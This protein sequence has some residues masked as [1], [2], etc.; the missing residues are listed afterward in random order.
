MTKNRIIAVIVVRDGRVVQSEKFKHNHVIHYDAIHAI[1]S[2]SRWNVDEIVVLNVSHGEGTKEGFLEIIEKVSKVCWVPLTA[3][4][5]I[6]SVDYGANLIKKGADKLIIN[7]SFHKQPEIPKELANKF[8]KQCIV[9]S[10]DVKDIDD[11]KIVHVDRGRLNTNQ[12][13]QIW[14]SHCEKH[15]A[16][17]LFINN[18]EFDGNRGGYD[19]ES[20][21]IA[22]EECKL[23]VIIFGGAAMDKHFAQGI[24]NGASGVAAANMF[25][26]KEMATKQIKRYL[27]RNNYSVRA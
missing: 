26:Y 14:I 2:F 19:L 24:E 15:G 5:F 16:G 17:E 21:K 20:L 22:T 12:S 10:I 4:G 23:P 11:K 3:G 13:L 18:I 9:A 8:G 1:E 7:S 25:H 6:N 27:I